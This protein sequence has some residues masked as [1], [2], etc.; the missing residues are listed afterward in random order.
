MPFTVCSLL[1]RTQLVFSH[2]ERLQLK[3]FSL[4]DF[5]LVVYYSYNNIISP[6]MALV[7]KQMLSISCRVTATGTQPVRDGF[8]RHEVTYFHYIILLFSNEKVILC[9]VA[10][11]YLNSI[12]LYSWVD[13]KYMVRFLK[14]TALKLCEN[15][16]DG[17]LLIFI[18][19]ALRVSCSLNK[20]LRRLIWLSNG[21]TNQTNSLNS[22]QETTCKTYVCQYC[23]NTA[24]ATARDF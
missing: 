10:K 23:Q 2:T 20:C 19:L 11:H 9:R 12:Y 17:Y 13:H 21:K 14:I 16:C 18:L 22:L 24:A 3:I 5:I 8:M 1:K 6:I 15:H 7:V 4:I